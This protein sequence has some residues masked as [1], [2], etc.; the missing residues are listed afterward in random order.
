MRKKTPEQVARKAKW[1]TVHQVSKV[2]E[3]PSNEIIQTLNDNTPERK[4][5]RVEI[6]YRD[7]RTGLMKP[8]TKAAIDRMAQELRDWVDKEPRAIRVTQFINKL[9]MPRSSFYKLAAEDDNL[10]H[11]MEYALSCIADRRELGAIFNDMG[12]NSSSAFRYLQRFDPEIRKEMEWEAKL[13]EK[14]QDK[15][16][17]INVTMPDFGDDDRV[18]PRI[19][20]SEKTF[21]DKT[22]KT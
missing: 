7:A 8:I 3:T 6:T 13:K 15:S 9:G 10:A 11:A 22:G 1:D 18:P 4:L 12:M 17:V 20:L 21:K 16:T 5:A 14:E 19:T 2:R